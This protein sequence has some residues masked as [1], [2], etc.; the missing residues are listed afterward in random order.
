M[1]LSSRANLS[2]AG[3][4]TIHAQNLCLKAGIK[5][6]P[7]ILQTAND[8]R[9]RKVSHYPKTK[10][11]NFWCVL[12]NS[13]RSVFRYHR[14]INRAQN[15]QDSN[16][17]DIPFKSV[18]LASIKRRLDRQIFVYFDPMAVVTELLGR[19]AS[20]EYTNKANKLKLNNMLKL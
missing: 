5:G 8:D 4:S 15:K 7:R 2:D 6:S 12:F 13:S 18:P 3:Q 16:S 1:S 17:R 14:G 19:P 11:A 10:T 9:K 20:H